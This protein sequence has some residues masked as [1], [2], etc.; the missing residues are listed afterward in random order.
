MNSLRP[1]EAREIVN[2]TF[3]NLSSTPKNCIESLLIRDGFYCGY[4]Y[5]FGELSA[6]WF[7]EEDEIKF[8]D[9]K[10]RTIRV[11]ACN[12]DDQRMAA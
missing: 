9:S 6:V 12:D 4:R 11:V 1:V 7:V 8:F 3:S 10:G 2:R 5:S